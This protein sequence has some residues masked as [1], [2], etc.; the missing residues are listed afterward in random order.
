M[1]L[2]TTQRKNADGSVVRYF[3]LAHNERPGDGRAPV[4]KVIHSFGRADEVDVAALERLCRSIARVVGLE[5]RGGATADPGASAG[6]DDVLVD[7]VDQHRTRNFGVVL[8]VESLWRELGMSDAL[9]AAARKEGLKA[10][11]ERALLAMVAN[12]LDVPTSKL[13]VCERWL[14]TVHLPGVDTLDSDQLY[15]AMDL[16]RRHQAAVERAVFDRTANLLHLTVDLVFYDT[17]T[18][19]FTVDEGDGDDGLRQYG[20]AKEADWRVKIVVAMA[21]TREGVP[22]SSWVLPGNTVDVTTIARV[23]ADLRDR[24]LGRVLLVGDSG[25]NSAD[26]RETLAKAC[27]RSVL[28]CRPAS[29]NEVAE[30]VLSRQGGYEAVRE[31]LRVKEVVVGEGELRRGPSANAGGTWAGTG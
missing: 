11:Y 14:D 9:G 20:R 3:Q 17:T 29:V 5:V 23:K 4:A 7:G 24:N 22:V 6:A 15:A 27:G 2:R 26:N 10:P 8:A 21:V 18:A 12:R 25:M 1:Y 30:D 16:L 31:N 13:G 28:A 19:S